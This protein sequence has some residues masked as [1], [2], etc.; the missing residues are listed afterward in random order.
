MASKVIL[1]NV[2]HFAKEFQS[3]FWECQ[4]HREE[5][6]QFARNAA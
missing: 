3:E 4:E 6:T 5:N 2:A 1:T